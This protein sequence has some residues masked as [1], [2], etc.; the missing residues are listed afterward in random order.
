MFHFP[1]DSAIVLKGG[2]YA[3]EYFLLTAGVFLFL[4]FGRGEESGTLRTPAQYLSNRFQRF[5]LWN[6]TAFLLVVFVKRILCEPVTSLS[7]WADFFAEDIW[8]I[9][10]VKFNGMN[11]NNMLVNSPAWTISSMLIVGF[12]IWTF[13]YY[14]KNLFLHI[15]VPISLIIGFGY[16]THIPTADHQLWIGFTTFGTFRTWLIMCLGYYCIPMSQKLSAVAFNK[17]GKFLLS[18]LELLIHVFAVIIIFKRAQRY[19]QW[20]ITLLFMLSLAIAMSGHSY[21]TVLCNKLS[22]CKLFGELSF[23]I[24]LSHIAVIILY[25]EKFSFAFHSYRGILMILLS[26]LAASLLHY[27]GTKLIKRLLCTLSR[28]F[29]KSIT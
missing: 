1:S 27:Y 28:I 22:C 21:L 9:L 29:K 16:W 15:I 6:V 5:F 8:E 3:V 12:L 11:N 14:Y 4:S 23:S 13:M 26:V 18:S 19:Y 10:M 20:L 24:Y 7:S 2:Y 25:R 17:R